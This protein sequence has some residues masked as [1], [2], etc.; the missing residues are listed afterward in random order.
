VSAV[1]VQIAGRAGTFEYRVELHLDAPG[2]LVL[3]GPNGAG[4][5]T[6]LKAILGALR[7]ER[8]RISI[9]GVPVFDSASAL[10]VPMELRAIGYVPQAYALFPHLTALEN[11][12]FGLPRPDR[13]RRALLMLE[14]LGVAELKDRLPGSLSGGERQRVALARALAPEPRLLLLDEPLAALDVTTRRQV[15]A[16]LAER[17]RSLEIPSIVVTHDVEDARTLGDRIAIL[18]RG[19]VV[20]SGDLA[21][22]L[23]RRTTPF[24]AELA[25]AGHPLQ[26]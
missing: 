18:E 12:G 15:R 8:G 1:E 6:A 5:S 17:L 20:D 11:A 3:A 19:S 22:V 14:R 4:K 21:S 9:G 7:P 24:A 23:Q 26:S 16:F 13:A 25:S 10:D 2:A